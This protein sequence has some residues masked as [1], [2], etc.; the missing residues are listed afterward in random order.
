NN[1]GMDIEDGSSKRQKEKEVSRNKQV[2]TLAN[3][4]F[5]SGFM[6]CVASNSMILVNKYVLSS[7]N[8]NAPI[9]LMLY[10]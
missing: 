1:E 6:Y 4:A 5:V 9:S 7:Y 2:I 10:Q 8:F 3:Q